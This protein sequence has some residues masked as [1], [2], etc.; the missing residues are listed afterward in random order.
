MNLNKLCVSIMAAGLLACQPQTYHSS[1]TP[2]INTQQMQTSEQ[3]L[4]KNFVSSVD[5]ETHQYFVYLPRGYGDQPNKQWPLLMFLHGNGERGN[6]RDEL[7][8]VISHGPLYEAWIQ[9]KDLPFIIISPQ[10]PMF[11]MDK[12]GIDYIDNR[13][14]A[15]IPQR[16]THGVP[17]RDAFQPTPGPIAPAPLVSDMSKT[18]P[19][20]P[21][22]WEM[23]ETDLLAMIAS[24]QKDYRVDSKR[25]YLTGLSYGG[26]GTWYMA[27]KHPDLF[28]AIIPVVG[29]GHPDLV[30]PIAQHKIP[31]WAF[32]GGRDRGVDKK[33]FYPGLNKLEELG[34]EEVRFTVE[35]DMA[36][37][38][39]KR[40]YARD[41]IYQ[42]LVSH[43]KP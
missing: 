42:W 16:L 14:R 21:V 41:D 18:P 7:D 17:A 1:P 2:T 11:G 4:R 25:I 24:A 38:T 30:A 39:W 37:D 26:F 34:S 22:G 6:G 15:Q 40:V 5:H 3:L 35:E 13:T 31:V 20:L 12:K 43:A 27:S 28:A 8:Y 23:V 33:F 36:H 32:A 19:L 10:L 29:W 9:K